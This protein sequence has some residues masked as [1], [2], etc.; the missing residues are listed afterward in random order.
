MSE[1]RFFSLGNVNGRSCFV[2]PDGAPFFSLGV[3]HFD[4][5]NLKYPLT[6]GVWRSRYASRANWI[7]TGVVPDLDAWGFNTIGLT[8]D[9]V[10]GK[11][12]GEKPD[13]GKPFNT[14]NST[15]Q[16]QRADFDRA[17]MPYCVAL[18]IAEN[19]GWNI[20]AIYP[21]VFSDE[22]DEKCAWIARALC[23]PHADSEN[24][25]GYFL[26]DCPAWYP[27]PN[28]RFFAG[29][30]P[31]DEEALRAIADRYYGTITR[32]IR[33]HDPNHLILGDRYNGNVGVPPAVLDAMQPYVD[34][35]SVQYFAQPTPQGRRE[36]RDALSNWHEACG[37]PILIA[38]TA[39]WCPTH[40]NP[41]RVSPLA[42]QAARAA[43]YVATLEAVAAEPWLVGW[44]WCSYV[45]NFSRGWGIKDPRDKP[46]EEFIGPVQ[47]FNRGLSA[48]LGLVR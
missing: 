26:V 33:A 36:M 40:D 14:G 4:E 23:E 12:R 20:N 25:V 44:H 39:N 19:E 15:E 16:W 8:T 3:N 18:R 21:D 29:T 24:L 47:E 7:D 37:K 13:W 46:Y 9:W 28:G 38:D 35:F 6:V 42:D 48:S 41:T 10:Y 17:G 22:W 31:A 1:S 2:D 34:V 45:E 5:S 11:R 27:H 30:D 32:H 43:D